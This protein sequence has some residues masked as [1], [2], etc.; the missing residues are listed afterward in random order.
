M[1]VLA[2]EKYEETQTKIKPESSHCYLCFSL[3]FLLTSF[4]LH[5]L[6]VAVNVVII[7]DPVLHFRIINLTLAPSGKPVSATGGGSGNVN[8]SSLMIFPSVSAVIDA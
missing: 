3:A 8:P 5:I 1:L 7:F 6:S 2:A 4:I